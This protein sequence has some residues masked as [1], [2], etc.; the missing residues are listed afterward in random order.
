[1]RKNFHGDRAAGFRQ[2]TGLAKV[3]SAGDWGVRFEFG[4]S[5]D[6]CWN[7]AG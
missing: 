6:L 3:T 1:M 4:L 2:E 5:D 7:R